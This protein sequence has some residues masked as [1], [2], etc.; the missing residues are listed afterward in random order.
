MTALGILMSIKE[1]ADHTR[2][3]MGG[4]ALRAMWRQ[5]GTPR[6]LSRQRGSI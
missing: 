4:L 3:A 2:H 1:L 5:S 6:P